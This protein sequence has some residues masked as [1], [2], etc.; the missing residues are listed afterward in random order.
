MASTD[1]NLAGQT[2]N[3]EI[4]VTCYDNEVP[5]FSESA[6]ERL[7]ENRYSSIPEWRLTGAIEGAST[8]VLSKNGAP[9]TVL[10]FRREMNKVTVINEVITISDA[11]VRRFAEYVFATYVDV[12]VI[13]FR[14]IETDVLRLPFPFQRVNYL[15]DIVVLLPNSEQD[16]LARLGPATRKNLNRHRNRLKRDFPTF[17][18]QIYEREEIDEQHVRAIV[19]FNWTRMA[20]K[21]NVSGFDERAIQRLISLTRTN[22]FVWVARI[23]GEICAGAICD[24]VGT[25]YFMKISAHDSAY[26]SYRLGTLC[27]YLAICACIKRGGSVTHLL[28]GQYEYKY[29]LLGIQR[30]LDNIVIYRDR[31]QQLRNGNLALKT[32]IQGHIRQLKLWLLHHQDR[33]VGRAAM[34]AVSLLRGARRLGGAA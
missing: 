14:A 3:Q 11:D 27:C 7:Y 24:S 23:D 21:N 15:E 29:L 18:Y 10:V 20:A 4:V 32:A 8:F 5:P 28:W 1:H 12:T 30:E 6:L 13:S 33:L 9:V 16:Y 2:E 26:D 17:S 34:A 22:G 31:I 19:K 25:H